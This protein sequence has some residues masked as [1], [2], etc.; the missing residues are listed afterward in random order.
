MVIASVEG[1]AI[2]GTDSFA[3]SSNVLYFHGYVFCSFTS[4]GF[5]RSTCFLTSTSVSLSGIRG[6]AVVVADEEKVVHVV[7][8]G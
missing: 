6:S 7:S 5:D 3:F 2:E 4:S 1:D 8:R